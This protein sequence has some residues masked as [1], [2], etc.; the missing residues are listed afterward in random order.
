MFKTS[1]IP[2]LH[3]TCY[4]FVCMCRWIEIQQKITPQK[5]SR[6]T[7]VVYTNNYGRGGLTYINPISYERPS[8][9]NGSKQSTQQI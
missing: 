9:Q 5:I 2:G 1:V 4:F 6:N 8:S 3:R 7:A